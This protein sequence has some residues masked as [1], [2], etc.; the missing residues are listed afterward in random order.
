[1]RCICQKE[2]VAPKDL[3][4]LFYPT[5]EQETALDNEKD[6]QPDGKEDGNHEEAEEDE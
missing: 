1:M 4:M 6:E 3:L 2:Y 5:V